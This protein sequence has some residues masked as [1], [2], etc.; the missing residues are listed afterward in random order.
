M[1]TRTCVSF[2]C[3]HIL[4]HCSSFHYLFFLGFNEIDSALNFRENL[5]KRQIEREQFFAFLT[6]LQ[7]VLHQDKAIEEVDLIDHWTPA[8][9][10]KS[11]GIDKFSENEQ[12]QIGQLYADSIGNRYCPHAHV[13]IRKIDYFDDNESDGSQWRNDGQ[14]V[15]AITGT[16]EREIKA[17]TSIAVRFQQ[18]SF[19]R[20]ICSKNAC[21]IE[22]LRKMCFEIGHLGE[23][24]MDRRSEIVGS[25]QTGSENLY[26]ILR[27]QFSANDVHRL[28]CC[29]RRRLQFAEVKFF[30]SFFLH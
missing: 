27:R 12:Q 11:V 7:T 14:V 26:Q 25:E 9:F 17:T 24:P 28:S 30:T 5:A 21:H 13:V 16:I 8:Q 4:P 29:R 10:V 3:G 18:I 22:Y 23:S 15:E 6:N 19:E 20:N 2:A 1:S